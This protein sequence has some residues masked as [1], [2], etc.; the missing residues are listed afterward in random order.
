MSANNKT[1]VPLEVIK[2]VTD[3]LN[4]AFE[5]LEPY[6]V[7]LPSE[8]GRRKPGLG[9]KSYGFVEKAY[10][11]ACQNP[12]LVPP[13][14]D[15]KE[16]EAD[17]ADAH[18]LLGVQNTAMQVLGIIQKRKKHSGS[19]A[20]AAALKLYGYVQTAVKQEIPGALE[21]YSE[22][23]KRFR[24]LGKKYTEETGATEAGPSAAL[25]D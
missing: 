16:F 3:H 18:A 12:K 19:G 10:A 1:A 8:K 2:K 13:F 24:S 11:F 20:V 22:L 5:E 4:K 14:L 6:T 17:F 21:V 25:D 9:D 15:M 7:N 23:K